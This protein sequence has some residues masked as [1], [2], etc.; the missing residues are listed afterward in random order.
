MNAPGSDGASARA[1]SRSRRRPREAW[2]HGIALCAAA[3]A[4]FA[5]GV[6][7]GFVWDD[8]R[9]I[10]ESERMQRLST[11]YEA[12]LHPSTWVIG[13]QADSPVVTYRP[14]ALAKLALDNALFGGDPRGFHATN[15]LLH[16]GCV[17]AFWRLL[18]RLEV[19]AAVAAALALVFAVH[20]VGA[21]AITWIN[22][23]SEP[24]CLLFGLLTLSLCATPQPA[25]RAVFAGIAFAQ[26]CALL[27]KETGIVFLALGLALLVRRG[28]RRT[29]ARGAAALAVGLCVYLAARAH[30]LAGAQH[31]RAFLGPAMAAVPA[32]WFRA[33]QVVV[34]PIDL[35]LENLVAWVEGASA[36]ERALFLPLALGWLLL[37]TL[38]VWRRRV[39]EAIGLAWWLG[40]LAPP[41]LT[42]GTGGYWPGLS[43]WVYVALPGLLLALAPALDVLLARVERRAGR[44]AL[45]GAGTALALFLALQAQRA[46]G[47]WESDERLLMHMIE[48][49]PHDWYGYL[50]LARHRLTQRDG[51][52]ALAILRRGRV[53]SGPYT[54]LTCLEG[55]TLARLGRCA[56]SRQAFT[57]GPDCLALAGIDA[58][59]EIGECHAARGEFERARRAL[60]LCAGTRA[61]CR[62]LLEQLPP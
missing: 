45:A 35:G 3:A 32:L 56:D 49:Y 54:K 36:F 14:L 8:H 61:R 17:L 6:S 18:G 13:D 28:D 37:W 48:S 25:S 44:V 59:Q 51:A 41:G 31:T 20:P 29:L 22:G 27:G 21:E 4:T 33:L 55:R 38:L 40:V 15:L 1:S 52:G 46:I 57:G 39:L 53:A 47:V 9:I 60:E 7:Y 34:L 12:F 26:C 10:P 50:M 42:L 16:L 11:V 2:L 19:S 43:R 24:I 58:W 23:C 30:A 62:G 5:R